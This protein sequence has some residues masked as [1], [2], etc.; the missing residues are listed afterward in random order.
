MGNQRELFFH[1]DS[2]GKMPLI[3]WCRYPTPFYSKN[4]RS[5]FLENLRE[6]LFFTQ[7][8]KEKNS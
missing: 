7:I 5:L 8:Y 4:L 3:N 6:P 1:A 2:C